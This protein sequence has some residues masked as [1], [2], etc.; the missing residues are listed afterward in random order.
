MGQDFSHSKHRDAYV[1]RRFREARSR[2]ESYEFK[3]NK[4]FL[5]ATMKDLEAMLRHQ[6]SEAGDTSFSL[7]YEYAAN[8]I[9]DHVED[10]PRVESKIREMLEFE[11]ESLDGCD[12]D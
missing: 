6:A 2:S 11:A 9:K 7:A 12:E 4:A 10:L 8:L 3:V 5:V 1:W